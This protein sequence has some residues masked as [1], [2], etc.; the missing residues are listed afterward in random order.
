MANII[1]FQPSLDPTMTPSGSYIVE[2]GPS[3]NGPWTVVA[4]LSAT[5]TGT[6]W[7]ATASMFTYMDDEFFRPYNTWYHIID[8]DNTGK[9]GRPSDPF[10]T[11]P[12]PYF[13]P[14]STPFG[15]FDNDIEFQKDADKVADFIRKKFESPFLADLLIKTEDSELIFGNTWN[16]R[17]WGICRGTGENLLGKILM[18]VRQ[19]LKKSSS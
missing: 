2:G 15:V 13:V 6:Y 8:V 11:H 17:V 7:N 9:M 5:M 18:K 12:T 4:Q 19:E 10:M 1:A 16:D 14:G 3:V